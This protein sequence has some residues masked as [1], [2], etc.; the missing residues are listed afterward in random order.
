M[1]ENIKKLVIEAAFDEETMTPSDKM[2]TFTEE[3]MSK[4]AELIV[5]ECADQII[6]KGTDWVDFTPSQT[7]VR[8]D[9]WI[10]AQE[11]KEEFGVE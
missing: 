2:Y 11:I 1:N 9:Y 3:K 6:E 7:G 4:F 5:R 10:V 8:Q